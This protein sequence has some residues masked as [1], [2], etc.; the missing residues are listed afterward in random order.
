MVYE[1]ILDNYKIPVISDLFKHSLR[2]GAIRSCNRPPDAHD[3]LKPVDPLYTHA[4]LS[5]FNKFKKQGEFRKSQAGAQ[6]INLA[7]GFSKA[8]SMVINHVGVYAKPKRVQ[9][10]SI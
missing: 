2:K 1:K 10:I 7:D 3:V 9:V 8:R 6:S 4:P 5:P